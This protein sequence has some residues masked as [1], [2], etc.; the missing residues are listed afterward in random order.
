MKKSLIRIVVPAALGIGSL[1]FVSGVAES[2]ASAAARPA[3][4]NAVWTGT[5][6]AV[7]KGDSFTYTSKSNGG[8]LVKYTVDYT[9]KT[10]IGPKGDKP[11]AKDKA[12]I[13]GYLKS[14]GSTVLEA[15]DIV[16]TPPAS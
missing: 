6:T 5:I 2:A 4:T 1:G 11:A 8:K 15:Q 9:A 12:K 13:T 16:L 3:I 14:A 7:G 10:K